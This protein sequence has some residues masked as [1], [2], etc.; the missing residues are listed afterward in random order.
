M[1]NYQQVTVISPL[2]VLVFCEFPS[3]LQIDCPG[4]QELIQHLLRETD[5]RHA[6]V[7]PSTDMVLS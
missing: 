2:G 1:S 5:A 3:I 7:G 4:I 6:L